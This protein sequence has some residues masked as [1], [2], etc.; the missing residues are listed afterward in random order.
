MD[1][2]KII[3]NITEE[4]KLWFQFSVDMAASVGMSESPNVGVDLETMYQVK[5][6]NH[7]TKK[8]LEFQ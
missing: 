8:Q 3:S 7:T 6:I 5:I 1:L 2:D 4:F